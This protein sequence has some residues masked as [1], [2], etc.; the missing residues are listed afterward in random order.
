MT[1]QQFFVYTGIFVLLYLAQYF[2][3]ANIL[4]KFAIQSPI[5]LKS[6]YTFHVVFTFLLSIAFLYLSKTKK[7]KDQLGF[8][9]LVALVLKIFLFCIVFNKVI[10]SNAS[11]STNEGSNLLTVIILPL[12]FEVFFISK[13]LKDLDAVKND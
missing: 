10:F 2:I 1:R 7:F 5:D 4:N 11:F 12:F 13:I 6:L 9:Y 8:L 3:H